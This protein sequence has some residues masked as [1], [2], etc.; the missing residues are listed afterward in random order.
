[1]TMAVIQHECHDSIT[2]MSAF[3]L[4]TKLQVI[5]CAIIVVL[6]TINEYW[7]A[8]ISDTILFNMLFILALLFIF[9]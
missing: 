6:L 4:I 8:D 3:R 9:F 1:M 2:A 5:C 7:V